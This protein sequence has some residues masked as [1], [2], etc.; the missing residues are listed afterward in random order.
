MPTVSV[1]ADETID[2]PEAVV[3]AQFGDVAHHQHARVHTKTRFDVVDDD[4]VRCHYTQVSRIGPLRLRQHVQLIRTTEGPLVNNMVGGLLDGGSISFHF[5]PLGTDRCGVRAVVTADLPAP[6]M[7]VAPL[8][9]RQIRRDL[10]AALLEDKR[11]LE[12]G[13]YPAEARPETGE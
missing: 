13:G 5:E 7:L 12:E 2:R 6:A 11:D 3:R 10:A 8:L 4:G 1:H 9:R